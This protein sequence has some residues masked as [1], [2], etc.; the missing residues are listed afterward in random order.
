[1][2]MIADTI[3]KQFRTLSGVL[4]SDDKKR[5]DLLLPGGEIS[6]FA[7]RGLDLTASGMAIIDDQCSIGIYGIRN[8][9]GDLCT[10]NID[11][12]KNH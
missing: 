10:S 12:V 1:M 9:G 5:I 4:V 2:T 3:L 11:H 7:G 8:D 6:A